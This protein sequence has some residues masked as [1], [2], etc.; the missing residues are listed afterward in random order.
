ML[1]WTVVPS[2]LVLWAAAV[3]LMEQATAQHRA[4]PRVKRR[5]ARFHFEVEA[6]VEYDGRQQEQEEI[7]RLHTS[8]NCCS[9][10]TV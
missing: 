3:Q 9:T 5:G 10:Q 1:L 7:V 6:G 8:H 2:A 4:Q